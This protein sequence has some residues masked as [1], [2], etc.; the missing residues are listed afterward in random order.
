MSPRLAIRLTQKQLCLYN[1]T[2]LP[3]VL[4]PP[5]VSIPYFN[6]LI[7]NWPKAPHTFNDNYNLPEF[8]QCTKWND[9][10]LT[11]SCTSWQSFCNSQAV[12]KRPSKIFG[13]T[14]FPELPQGMWITPWVYV[15]PSGS[16]WVYGK[17]LQIPLLPQ[18]HKLSQSH[19]SFIHTSASA[20]DF[21]CSSALPSSN[22]P[23]NCH[24]CHLF[25]LNLDA[26]LSCIPPMH[27]C[28]HLLHKS[29]S[30]L[31]GTITRFHTSFH[32]ISQHF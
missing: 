21:P 10:V 31:P 22:C 7:I 25:N 23:P 32:P 12:L 4:L 27:T 6:D 3:T 24:Q 9:K 28:C 16:Y 1:N 17:I 29:P 20:S 19:V 14:S 8:L 18:D 11:A 26:V 13:C 30:P 5:T 15:D 2:Y